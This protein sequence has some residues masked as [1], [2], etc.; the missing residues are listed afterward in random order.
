MTVQG[1]GIHTAFMMPLVATKPSIPSLRPNLVRR[2]RLTERLNEGLHRRSTLIAAPA[3]FGKTTLVGEWLDGGQRRVAWLSLEEEDGEPLRFLTYLIAALQ[4]VVGHVGD[5]VLISLQS[6][7]PPP[8][9]ALLTMLVNDLAAIPDQFVLVL[10]DYHVLDA[11]PVDRAVTFLLEHLPPRMHLVIATREE[12]RLPLARLRAKDQ[13]TELRATDLRFTLAEV[14]GFLNETMGLALSTEEIKALDERVEGW[15]AGLQLVALSLQG[16]QD[17][18]GFIASFTGGHSFVLD[19]LVE[20]VLR[21]QPAAM[22]TFLLRC[23]ILERFCGPLCEAVVLDPATPGQATLEY[24][25]RANL[26]I[27]PLDGERRWYRF[28]HLFAD[29]LRKRL[30]LG[31]GASPSEGESAI[32]ELHRR[33]SRWCEEH[34][35]EV[36]AFRHAVAGQDIERAARLMESKGMPRHFPGVVSLLVAWLASLPSPELDARPSLRVW[37]ASLLVR[38]GQATGAEEKLQ[39]AEVALCGGEHDAQARNLI[40]HIASIRATLALPRYDVDTLL[41]QS[42]RALAYLLPES[43]ALRATACWT[44]GVAY[45]LLGERGEA[46]RVY[47]EAIALS[48]ASGDT[49]IT[50]LATLGMGDIQGFQLQL[51]LAAESYRR[52]L[53]LA[54]DRPLPVASEAHLGLGR[55]CYE[56]NDLAAA[57]RHGHES[58]RLA[59]QYDGFIDRFVMGEVLLARLCLARGDVSGAVAL[60]DEADQAARQQHFTERIP[61]IAAVRVLALLRRGNVAAAAHLAVTYALPLSQTRVSLAEG[62]LADA[63]EASELWRQQVEAKGLADERLKA[64][65][66]LAMV[67]QAR[68]DTGDALRVLD[69]ALELAAPGGHIRS[70]VD[71]GAAMADLLSAAAAR[72]MLPEYVGRLRTALADEARLHNVEHQPAPR[73]QGL[74]EPLSRREQEVLTLIAQG[75]ANS[76]V[77]ERLV[78]ALDTVKGHNRRIFSKLQVQRRTEAIAKARSLNLLP[79]DK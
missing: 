54:G 45:V 20:E 42:R 8:N 67:Y 28:H 49:F 40:G 11:E 10:D 61:E 38:S 37:Y 52:V 72:G 65:A 44:L 79:H 31:D 24:L 60:L 35:L 3:G 47:A 36:D 59:R 53:H 2:S 68:G 39:A 14:A 56:L 66:L 41:V 32:A 50:M 46:G 71:E 15:I 5:G 25:E 62:K 30:Q 48:Q 1:W 23:S 55:I 57:E 75:F 78:I 51:P 69:E 77:A 21:R 63:L 6:P 70:F 9:D 58:L 4:T 33:A 27:V 18:A 19:Y 73:T 64:L 13:L 76:E 43:L 17:A 26:F 22:Q 12:P 7:Q 29:A 16:Q 34:D 74:V